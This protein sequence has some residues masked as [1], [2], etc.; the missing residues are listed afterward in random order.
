MTLQTNPWYYVPGW[1]VL[2][3]IMLAATAGVMTAVRGVMN[4]KYYRIRVV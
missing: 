3:L 2:A 4:G 1:L